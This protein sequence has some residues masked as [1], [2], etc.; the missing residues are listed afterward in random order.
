M[1][2]TDAAGFFA[3]RDQIHAEAHIELDYAFECYGDPEL[4]S[5]ALCSEQSTAQWRRVGVDE[6]YRPCFAAKVL[7]LQVLDRRPAPSCPTAASGVDR[8]GE[9]SVCRV[10][11]AHPHA[12]FG[13]RIPNLL[14]AVAGEGVYFVPGI[15]LIKLMDL[16]LPATYLAGFEGPRFGVA[17]I[18]DLLQVYDRPIFFGVIKPNIGLPPG[19]LTELGYQG[20]L[21][22][23]DVA[24][25]D[26]MLADTP[27]CPLAERTALLG[28]ARRRAEAQTGVPKG[29]MANITDEV[30]RL[31]ELH[32]LAVARG[33]N[34]LLVNAM[35]VG[36]SAVRMLRRHAR[37]PLIGHFAFVAAASR[38]P[39][40]GVHTRVINR[41]QRLAGLDGVIIPGFGPRMGMDEAE[42]LA[43]VGACL[44]PLGAIAP[45]LPI[46]GGSEWAGTLEGVYRRVGGVDFG[47]IPGRGVFGHPMGPAAGATS[48][49]QAWDA[50]RGGVTL[51]EQ[52]RGCPELRAAIDAFA[53]A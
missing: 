14:S 27:R 35:T 7:D 4:A 52:A 30:E 43:G 48:V 8:A 19:P 15:P 34:L 45:S 41:L 9:V 33:A 44:G 1:N 5:A 49:R 36:L 42:V 11:I 51:A 37:V 12:N 22:G 20:W 32:D 24:K 40:Y 29:Y 21:G 26:E 16:R 53:R 28:E 18:R 46:P 23:L 6:D 10:T 50:I 38:L 25:D 3:R 31:C 39:C 13:P 17:G 2:P 47:F